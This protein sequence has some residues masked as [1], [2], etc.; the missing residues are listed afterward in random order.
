[1]TDYRP[2]LSVSAGRGF[3]EAVVLVLHGGREVSIDPVRGRQLAVLRMVPFAH[4]IRQLGQGR[5]AVARL[6][7]GARG[8]NARGGVPAPV[9]DAEWALS[10]LTDRFGPRPIGLVGHS[11]GGRTAL[12]VGGHTGVRGVVGLAPWLP[13]DEPVDQLAGRRVLLAH[14]TADRMTSPRGTAAFASRLEA[15]HVPVSL[16]DITGEGHPML[17]RPALWHDLAAQFVLATVLPDYVPSGWTDAPNFIHE[18]LRA[19][20]RLTYR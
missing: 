17:R 10:Q 9:R 1:M 2:H 18:V 7:Y 4:R 8:W 5:V 6:R 12:R 3:P 14:G 19:P 16:V 20:T 11:M 15:A 13:A